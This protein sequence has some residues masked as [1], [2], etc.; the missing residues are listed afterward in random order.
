MKELITAIDKLVN[1]LKP[2][3]DKLNGIYERSDAMIAI[4]PGNGTRFANHIDNTTRDGRRLTVV[5]YLNLGWTFEQ[6]GALRLTTNTENSL[7]RYVDVLPISGRLA[8]FYSSEMA[9]EVMPTYGDRLAITIWY[10]DTEERVEALNFA[11]SSGK[12]V[13]VSKSSVESQ[14]KAQEF[15][16]ELVNSDEDSN[17]AISKEIMILTQKL[18]NLSDETV[19]IIASVIGVKSANELRNGFKYMNSSDLRNMRSSF[20]RMGLNN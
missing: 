5:I 16:A 15:I 13:A 6:G 12:A 7:T 20:R 2:R 3:V 8:M 18:N 11:K 14:M 1:E 17:E 4:Y 10:Y 9:H 19:G